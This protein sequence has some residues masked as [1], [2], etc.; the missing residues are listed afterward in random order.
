MD[1]NNLKDL[2]NCELRKIATECYDILEERK[3]EKK[4]ELIN[5]LREACFNLRD[6]GIEVRYECDCCGEEISLDFGNLY[7]N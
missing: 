6:A 1:I 4:E 2:A 5:A 7:F 3:R